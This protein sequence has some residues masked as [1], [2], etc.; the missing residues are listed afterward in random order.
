MSDSCECQGPLIDETE[1]LARVGGDRELLAELIELFRLDWPRQRAELRAALAERNAHR[2]MVAAHTVKGS[3][4]TFGA[5]RPE[6][7]A[8][9]LERM[10]RAENL[11]EADETVA[12]LEETVDQLCRE[13]VDHA[14]GII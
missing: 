6:D 5:C 10:G 9:Q 2:V 8:F 11:G 12:L 7:L 3:V 4:S 14:A 13:L 1:A